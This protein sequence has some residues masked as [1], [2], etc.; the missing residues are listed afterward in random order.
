MVKQT[1][2]WNDR[3]LCSSQMGLQLLKDWKK[4]QRRVERKS[5]LQNCKDTS[6]EESFLAILPV[7]WLPD[8]TAYGRFWAH[9]VD[10]NL[11][12]LPP[13]DLLCI[14]VT[15]SSHFLAWHHIDAGGLQMISKGIW[16][17]EFFP[18]SENEFSPSHKLSWIQFPIPLFLSA[19]LHLPSHPTLC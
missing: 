6:G 2:Q 15:F 13:K 11:Q 18:F 14:P 16:F 7:N 1:P 3:E 5:I 12:I 8:L 10:E 17:G 4:I 9:S 19:P